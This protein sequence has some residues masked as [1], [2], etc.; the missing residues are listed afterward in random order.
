MTDASGLA[1]DERLVQL[2]DN[3]LI[4]HYGDEV[5]TTDCRDLL[6]ALDGELVPRGEL[7]QTV[8]YSAMDTKIA[9]QAAS[10]AL[11]AEARVRELE[12]ARRRLIGAH[13]KA[14]RFAD[15]NYARWCSVSVERDQLRR[16]VA[17]VEA[18]ADESDARGTVYS[19]YLTTDRIRAALSDPGSVL[20]E[21]LAQERRALLADI[22]EWIRQY[23]ATYDN[24]NAW[25]ARDLL[26]VV[27]RKIGEALDPHRADERSE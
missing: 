17:A 3:W 26:L 10:R 19:G 6:A 12:A 9:A 25:V 14:N 15:Q 4:R 11:T 20:A 8:A 23:A 18:Y 7:E 27:A 13:Q 22:Q 16:Q 5:R 24:P 2:V 1:G 21:R